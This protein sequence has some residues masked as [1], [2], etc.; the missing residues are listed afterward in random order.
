MEKSTH[1]DEEFYERRGMAAVEG[2]IG[3]TFKCKAWLIEAL[4]HKSYSREHEKTNGF[5]EDYERLE[6]LG[7]AVLGCLMARHFFLETQKDDIRK[8]PKELHKMKTS[9][10]NNNLLS[11]IVIE[12]GIHEYMIYNQKAPSFREQFGGYVDTVRSESARHGSTLQ[13]VAQKERRLRCWLVC[14]G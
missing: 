6:F 8:N 11:L 4:T 1:L 5:L 14:A 9:V 10:I 12:N 13:L 2:I 7:D 3:Y